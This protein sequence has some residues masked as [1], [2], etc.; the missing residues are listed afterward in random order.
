MNWLV[1]LS[2][3]T[4]MTLWLAAT[5]PAGAAELP[6]STPAAE[7]M[8][9]EKLAKVGEIMN[10]LIEDKK[11]AGGT[12]LVARN[13]K[14]MFQE[15]YGLRNLDGKLPVERDTIFR[16]YS[17]S[18]AITSAAALMLVDE[19]RLELDAP[20]AK[21]LPAFAEMKVV[22]GEAERAAKSPIAVKDLFLHT[23]GITYGKPDG[24]PTEKLFEAVDVLDMPSDL[25]LMSTKLGQIPLEFDPGTQWK[26]GASIDVLGYL[27]QK[28]SGQPL[29]VFLKERIFEPLEM[30]DTG[31]F[32]PAEKQARFAANYYS[33]GKGRMIIRDDPNK[34]GY[35]HKP[36]LASGG[37]GLVGTASDYM[38]FLLMIENGGQ[39]QG[40]RILS[41]ES[42][43]QMRTNQL[44]KGVDWIGFGNDKRPGIGF[45]LG[46]SVTV[47]KNEKSPH[48]RIDEYGWGGAAST[49]Y[50]VS[51]RD[52]L[53]VV[54]MEQ[55][56][57]YS[58]ETEEALKPVIYDAI[59][60]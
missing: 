31:F 30:R 13:G 42:V 24:S 22:D 5:A 54:T 23:S 46:F 17:M 6:A 18:K 57:P 20:V 2:W 11:I 28:V 4:L 44:P 16:I 25:A 3:L 36:G 48:N 19:G 60:K 9:A 52:R 41:A 43:L 45:G 33:N 1:R 21:Y 47:E 59:V 29:D 15:T 53:V 40:K 39:W 7:G 38:R 10:R 56:W 51:P 26:Y 49:H 8:S 34:S 12:V 32:V 37:G 58:P 27:V 55:R 50:W 14:L 35:L